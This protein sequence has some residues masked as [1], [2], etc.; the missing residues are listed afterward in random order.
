MAILA[1][2][3]WFMLQSAAIA[4]A[5]DLSDLRDA[6][7]VVAMHTRYGNVLLARLGLLIGGNG[8]R[9][10]H[11]GGA[12]SALSD[13]AAGRRRP[14][15]RARSATPAPPRALMGDGLVVSEALH[16]A[17]AGLWLGALLPLGI[18]LLALPPA[19]AASVCERFT[20]IG[21]GCVLVLAGTGLA[22]GLELIGGLPALFGTAYGHFALLKIALFV[23]RPG[24]GRAEPALADRPAGGG[25][26]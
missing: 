7:P 16:L 12:H 21:L 25:G 18:T 22:Q 26:R 3:A 1:G 13:P 10:F 23:H 19:Q 20:P 5:D 9:G 14:A 17:A 15:F 8:A 6:L 11:A 4:G 2:A 24:A